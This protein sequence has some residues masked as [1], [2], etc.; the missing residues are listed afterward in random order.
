MGLEEKNIEKEIA[1]VMA[2]VFLERKLLNYGGIQQTM[3]LM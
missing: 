2:I 1:G 3:K